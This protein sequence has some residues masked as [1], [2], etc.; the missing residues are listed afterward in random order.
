MM[1]PDESYR[2]TR[3]RLSYLNAAMALNPVFRPDQK[4]AEDVLELPDRLDEAW[5][6]MHN[7]SR[8]NSVAQGALRALGEKCHEACVSI[9]ASM[10][11]CYRRDAVSSAAIRR[12]PTEDKTPEKTLARMRVLHAL[13]G[14]LPNAPGTEGPLVVGGWTR[15][16]F[17]A[18]RQELDA[19]ITTATV[20]RLQHAMEQASYM[21]LN[22]G[23]ENFINAA[24]VQ[25]RAL[26]KPG[27]VERKWIDRVPTEP[28]TQKPKP[29]D[30]TRAFSPEPGAVRLEF[31][32]EHATS[33]KVLYK[34]PDDAEFQ[35]VA[36]VLKPGVYMTSGLGPG[37][38]QFQIVPVN[39]RGPGEPGEIMSIQV[40]AVAT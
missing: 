26:F 34:G 25:G 37:T 17:E 2:F 24:L 18:A 15:E 40:A 28:G 20:A 19:A 33:F 13:W 38:H 3:T 32:A 10:K 36:E 39:S 31:E 9:Y 21:R 23:L 7:K 5:S 30:I 35:E 11:S 16:L 1:L 4:T 29:P 6:L 14:L 8:A 12:V 22:D 27:T